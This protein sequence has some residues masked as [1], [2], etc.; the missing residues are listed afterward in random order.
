MNRI[1]K[2]ATAFVAIAVT[3]VGATLVTAPLTL[4]DIG[5]AVSSHGTSSVAQR[6]TASIGAAAL[7][8]G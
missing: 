5:P 8:H 3:L 6:P 7:R 1:Q 4:A 2:T